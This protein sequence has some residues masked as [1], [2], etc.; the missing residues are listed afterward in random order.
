[1]FSFSLK[2]REVLQCWFIGGQVLLRQLQMNKWCAVKLKRLNN[3]NKGRRREGGSV[4]VE[5]E[6]WPTCSYEQRGLCG[7][8]SCCWGTPSLG[9]YLS[10]TSP[11]SETAGTERQKNEGFSFH[12]FLYSR[13]RSGLLFFRV[14]TQWLLFRGGT[15]P[16]SGESGRNTTAIWN[17]CWPHG[18]FDTLRVSCFD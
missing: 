1:M 17:I 12:S 8:S 3:K 16:S 5:A 2:Q 13:G 7:W 4:Q 18:C 14:W 15:A 11:T 6:V 9:R 10:W